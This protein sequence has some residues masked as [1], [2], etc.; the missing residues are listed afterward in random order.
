MTTLAR[1]QSTWATGRPNKVTKKT[2]R[3]RLAAHSKKPSEAT[4]SHN[5]KTMILL[6]TQLKHWLQEFHVS[7]QVR[8]LIMCVPPSWEHGIPIAQRNS[9]TA[10]SWPIIDIAGCVFSILLPKSE[11]NDRL[12]PLPVR[13]GSKVEGAMCCPVLVL[14]LAAWLGSKT[15]TNSS[16]W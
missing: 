12:I 7:S 4:P 2:P 1:S 9:R 6:K 16:T 14:P 8:L 10:S 3:I 11:A 15:L 5:N 13:S